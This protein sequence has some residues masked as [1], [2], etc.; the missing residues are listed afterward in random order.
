[1]LC[2]LLVLRYYKGLKMLKRLTEEV[3]IPIPYHAVSIE[4]LGIER[5]FIYQFF[6]PNQRNLVRI[7]PFL[8]L[9]RPNDNVK[10]EFLFQVPFHFRKENMYVGTG[11]YKHLL[12]ETNPNYVV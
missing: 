5:I 10:T 6:I 11:G 1:M 12:C 3:V 8:K 2:L 4:E 7:F 9:S